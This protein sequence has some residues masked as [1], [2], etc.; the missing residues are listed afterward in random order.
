MLHPSLEADQCEGTVGAHRPL[1]NLSQQSN[2][3][4]GGEARDQVVELE[5]E[6]RVA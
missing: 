5:Y 2:V 1:S 4:F 6:A 3:P